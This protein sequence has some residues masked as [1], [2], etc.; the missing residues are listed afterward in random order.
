MGGTHTPC[1]IVYTS[2]LVC[3]MHVHVHTVTYKKVDHPLIPKSKDLRT[4]GILTRNFPYKDTCYI[5]DII[6]IL[7]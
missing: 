1:M 2:Y 5:D 6:I 7:L 4:K 3:H